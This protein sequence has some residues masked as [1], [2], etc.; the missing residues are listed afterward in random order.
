MYI[1][2]L[3]IFSKNALKRIGITSL[4]LSYFIQLSFNA[5]PFRAPTRLV[6]SEPSVL[7]FRPWPWP[8]RWEIWR[9]LYQSWELFSREFWL[10]ARQCQE[11]KQEGPV[12]GLRECIFLTSPFLCPSSSFSLSFSLI[13]LCCSPFVSIS[14][15]K[16]LIGW[17]AE[18]WYTTVKSC[19]VEGRGGFVSS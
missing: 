11:G 10:G 12:R 18:N 17:R 7:I 6:G 2:Q 15:K 14:G 13:P 16:H 5:K 1:S 9:S 3:F 8:W 4:Q 19:V